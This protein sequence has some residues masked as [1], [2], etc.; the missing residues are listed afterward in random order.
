MLICLEGPDCGGKTTLAAELKRQH[1]ASNGEP[2]EII[3]TGPPDPYDRDVYEEYELGLEK[4]APAALSPSK[5]VILDRW[6]LGDRIYAR[7]RPG[8]TP[9]LTEEGL[10]HVDMAV[11]SLGVVKAILNPRLPV[12]VKRLARDGDNY[13]DTADI[14]RIRHEYEKTGD[15][16][17][18]LSPN[19]GA[20]ITELARALLGLAPMKC[21]RANRFAAATAGT[22][23]GHLWPEAVLFGDERGPA[24][25]ATQSYVRPFTPRYTGSASWYLLAALRSARLQN[26]VGLVNAG[27]PGVDLAAL[28]AELSPL[29]NIVALGTRASERLHAAGINHSKVPHPQY[30][31][32]FQHDQLSEYGSE[33]AK[34]ARRP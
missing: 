25:P 19:T 1:D 7:Y 10:L 14:G 21:E 17:G 23:T 30:V 27:E 3:H 9:R 13:I 8:K 34:V 4:I 16:L 22:Y 5:L 20:P 18:W 32:R 12:L 11:S 24:T 6:H 26:K 2:A 33:I 28:K 31:R 15:T 29:V